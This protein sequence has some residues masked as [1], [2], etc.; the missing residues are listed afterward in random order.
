MVDMFSDISSANRENI[1]VREYTYPTLTHGIDAYSSP[2]IFR[3]PLS[4]GTCVTLDFL[5]LFDGFDRYSDGTVKVTTGN[6]NTQGEYLL[7]DKPMD[8]FADAEP[9]L[10]AYVIFPGD[11]FKNQEIEIRMGVYT[12]NEPIQPLFSDY[13]Y[14]NATTQY[15]HS[16]AYANGELVLSPG[17]ETQQTVTLADGTTIYAAGAN[18]PFYD[19]GESAMTGLL[20]R[21]WLNPDPSAS[22]GEGMSEQPYI[23]IRYADVLL[24]A[25][26]AAVELALEGQSSPDGSNLLQ[27]ATDA[28]NDIRNRAGAVELTGTLT[29]TETGRNI[30]RKER[31]KELAFEHKTK[32]D[33]RRWRVMHYE[34]REDFWGEERDKTFFSNE[35]NFRFRGLYPFISA[36]T[37][38]YFFDAHFQAVSM[39]TFS[40]NTVDYYF[41]VPGGEV[42]KSSVIDQQPNR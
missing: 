2:Y 18:G 22:I 29:A 16:T 34:N 33:L 31:R 28:I 24:N 7:Y 37:G 3:A 42:T 21:K 9:R 38:K 35:R 1:L 26:E 17:P 27:V 40:Y 14:A 13:S 20:F 36:Q 6:T 11:V 23:L 12:G 19:T 32:W 39:K 25:A 15:Q 4:S 30:V 5:E 41:A 8:F 10:R